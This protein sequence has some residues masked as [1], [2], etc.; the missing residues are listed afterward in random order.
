MGGAMAPLAPL[1]PLYRPHC[2]RIGSYFI[3]LNF[4]C[5]VFHEWKT[6]NVQSKSLDIFA[7]LTIANFL[8]FII[9]LAPFRGILHSIGKK[10]ERWMKKK[11]ST[12]QFFPYTNIWWMFYQ[13]GVHIY[14]EDVS[15]FKIQKQV[16]KCSKRNT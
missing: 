14:L 12:R 3:N 16:F 2:I 7:L 4:F 9:Y 5:S 8:L 11:Y 6:I 15:W 10:I 1:A 13:M